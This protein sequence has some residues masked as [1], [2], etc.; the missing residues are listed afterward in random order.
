MVGFRWDP[1]FVRKRLAAD[2]TILRDCHIDITLKDVE[3]AQRDPA[4]I[5]NW[6]A[7]TRAVIDDLG[8]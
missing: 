1:T 6:V 4:R 3:T 5:R 7:V 8:N 2:L